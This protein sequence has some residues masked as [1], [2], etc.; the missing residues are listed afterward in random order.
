MEKI[1]PKPALTNG[2]IELLKLFSFN[3]ESED[4]QQLKRLLTRFL[5][6]K[7]DKLTDEHWDKNNFND[8][9]METLLSAHERTLYLPK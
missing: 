9:Y 2:Q 5:A 7:L 8:S 6:E 3:M 1:M 4:I